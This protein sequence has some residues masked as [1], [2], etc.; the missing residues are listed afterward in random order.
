MKTM[1]ETQKIIDE[2]S[3]IKPAKYQDILSFFNSKSLTDYDI[4]RQGDM[5]I[6][7]VLKT[8][9]SV[10][11]YIYYPFEPVYNLDLNKNII[12]LDDRNYKTPVLMNMYLTNS[13]K[14]FNMAKNIPIRPIRLYLDPETRIFKGFL[15]ETGD[16]IEFNEN[17][18]IDINKLDKS[19]IE[20]I[21]NYT[22][23]II[24]NSLYVK[25][26]TMNINNDIPYYVDRR[27]VANN[28]IQYQLNIYDFMI[29]VLNNF[30]KEQNNAIYR[31]TLWNIVTNV[32]YN[33]QMKMRLTRPIFIMMMKIIFKLGGEDYKKCEN[34]IVN[35]DKVENVEEYILCFFL[36]A[37]KLHVIDDQNIHHLI[38]M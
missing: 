17:E 7:F 37:K 8:V 30:M 3:Y 1:E 27:I 15:L 6:G 12:D 31:D 35:I 14:L 26:M 33:I 32:D 10:K 22:S 29:K 9:K 21:R 13:V 24:M 34:E 38:E 19:S 2:K 25:I 36:S 18:Y 28:M 4:I 5:Y 16:I 23:N 20:K 11:P